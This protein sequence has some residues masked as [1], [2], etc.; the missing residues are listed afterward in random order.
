MGARA[1]RSSLA[2]KSLTEREALVVQYVA[3]GLAN[4]EIGARMSLSAKTIKNHVAVIFCK[5]E[6][7]SRTALVAWA[8]RNRVAEAEAERDEARELHAKVCDQYGAAMAEVSRL[9]Q[10]VMFGRVRRAVNAEVDYEAVAQNGAF[11]GMV[12]SVVSE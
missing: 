7:Q 4:K 5:A 1:S 12:P 9:Q 3:E 2:R 11:V 6:V 8:F 10:R